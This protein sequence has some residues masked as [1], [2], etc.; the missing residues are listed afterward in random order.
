[1]LCHETGLIKQR[2]VSDMK[3]LKERYLNLDR[4]NQIRQFKNYDNKTAII[5]NGNGYRSPHPKKKSK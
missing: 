2:H 4:S 5:F 1:M 3:I